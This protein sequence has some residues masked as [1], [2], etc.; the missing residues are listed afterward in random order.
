MRTELDEDGDGWPEGNGNVERPGMGEEK[1]DNAV[2][3][4]RALYD[5]ADMASS[6]GQ[7]TAAAAAPRRAGRAARPLRGRLVDG[8]RGRVRGL[9]RTT[10]P[11]SKI[12]QKHWIGADPMEA[13]LWIDGEVV[14]GLADFDHGTRALETR[15]NNCYSG[16][17]PGNR[18]LF[19]TGCGGGPT[20][21]G[22]F[23][24]FSLNTGI[25]IVGEG[26]YGRLGL[27]S[28]SGTPRRTP[29]RSSPS[30]PRAGRPTSSRARCRRSCR[31]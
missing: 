20:G 29:R 30:R 15:E 17:R 28:S 2:Y 7:A 9:A 22:E 19:H 26:N 3:Y 18:G 6:A 5:Y 25:M 11:A 27:S 31:R 12:N 4:I 24:I 8:G 16:E 13:E 21:A 23:A 14:P 10:R 1:L